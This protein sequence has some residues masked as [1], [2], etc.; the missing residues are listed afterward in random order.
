VIQ[1]IECQTGLSRLVE[2]GSVWLNYEI[3]HSTFYQTKPM[4]KQFFHSDY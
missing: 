4:L 3:K 2:V 1:K